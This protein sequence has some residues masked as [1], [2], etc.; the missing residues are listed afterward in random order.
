MRRSTE[1]ILVSHAGTLPRP[2]EIVQL[3]SQGASGE[4][5]LAEKLPAAVTAIVRKQVEAG[6]DIVND[7]EIPKRGTF[8]SYIQE[9]IE[10]IEPRKFGV[11]QGP[12]P[13]DVN[14]RD[15]KDFPG[16]FSAGLGGFGPARGTFG[17]ASAQPP[18]EADRTLQFCTAPLRYVGRA[19]AEQDIRNLKAACAGLDVE[20]W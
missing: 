17:G 2:P 15:R 16:F 12:P 13:R 9:R 11:G 18:T 8:S 7:G 6:V 4:A 3:M 20:P 10:G 1:R 14:G 19:G 5:E